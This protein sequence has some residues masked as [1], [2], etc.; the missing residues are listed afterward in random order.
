M[1]G[2]FVTGTDT[3]VGKTVLAASLLAA[4]VQAGEPVAAFK[5]VVTGLD[6]EEAGSGGTV[7]WPPDHELLATAAGC[8]AEDVAPLRFGPAVSPHFAAELGGLP[9]RPC[10][11]RAR[12]PSGGRGTDAGR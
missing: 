5:P 10:P 3:G 11:A 6:E 4:M 1:R 9:D 2:V 7:S 12:R 8:A